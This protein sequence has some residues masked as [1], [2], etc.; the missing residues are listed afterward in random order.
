MLDLIETRGGYFIGNAIL[1]KI[2]VVGD[3]ICDFAGAKT[4]KEGDILTKDGLE[5]FPDLLA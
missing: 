4:V 3:S 2:D 5:V 1:D